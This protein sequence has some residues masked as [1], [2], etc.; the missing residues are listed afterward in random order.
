M[1]SLIC[2]VALAAKPEHSFKADGYAAA[3][4]Q[5]QAEE[6]D[7]MMKA[8]IPIW[9]RVICALLATGGAVALVADVLGGSVLGI[10][11]IATWVLGVFGAITCG[12]IAVQKATVYRGV[13]AMPAPSPQV[14]RLVEEHRQLE[15]IKAYRAEASATLFEAKAVLEHYW[16]D[17]SSRRTREKRR[18]A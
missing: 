16:P 9:Q 15:A 14:G 17:H 18:A 5:R 12:R 3:Q 2:R 10:W 13:D 4:F 6:A 7:M 11:G 1:P 8:S